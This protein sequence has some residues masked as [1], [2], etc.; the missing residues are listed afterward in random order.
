[1][2]AADNQIKSEHQK[3]QQCKSVLRRMQIDLHDATGLIQDP[4][5]LKAALKVSFLITFNAILSRNARGGKSSN[6]LEKLAM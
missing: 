4:L 2:H 6:L 3:L 1:M 5:K